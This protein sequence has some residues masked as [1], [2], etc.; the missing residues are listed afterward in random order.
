M[1]IRD[2]EGT[3]YEAA[4]REVVEG[5]KHISAVERAQGTLE[6]VS[7]THL[8]VYK[9][10]VRH[11]SAGLPDAPKPVSYTHLSLARTVSHLGHQLTGFF[12]R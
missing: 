8:D 11:R 2:S 4:V 10:Q 12:L 9:R 3:E 1:C 6:T 5:A 7:Y